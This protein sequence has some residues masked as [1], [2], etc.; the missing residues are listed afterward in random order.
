MPRQAADT[1]DVN[2]LGILQTHVHADFVSGHAELSERTGA[3]IFI[4]ES[5]ANTFP[6][7]ELTGNEVDMRCAFASS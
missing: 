6:R 5:P 7:T 4:G 3:S 1:A 2:I